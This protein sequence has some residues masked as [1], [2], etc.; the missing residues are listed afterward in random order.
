MIY[1]YACKN[2]G[3]AETT[4]FVNLNKLLSLIGSA[5]FLVESILMKYFLGVGLIIIGVFI[6]SGTLDYLIRLRKKR[7]RTNN[8][9]PRA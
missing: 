8:S 1:N 4:I 7:R 2:I 3:P 9:T 5:L 6:G